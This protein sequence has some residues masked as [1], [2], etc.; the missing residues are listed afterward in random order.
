MTPTWPHFQPRFPLK[1]SKGIFFQLFQ[2]S[3][4]WFDKCRDPS[5]GLE[6]FW[7]DLGILQGYFGIFG[8]FQAIRNRILGFST[9]IFGHLKAV[10]TEFWNSFKGSLVV[11]GEGQILKDR[12][13]RVTIEPT[14]LT[15]AVAE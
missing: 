9:G 8:Y 12:L 14:V 6:A 3:A 4:A 2:R 13:R 11:V 1:H 7:I 15:L 5:R 10:W